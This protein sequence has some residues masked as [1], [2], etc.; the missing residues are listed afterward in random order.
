MVGKNLDRATF[1]VAETGQNLKALFQF[2]TTS[3]LF[4]LLRIAFSLI[5]RSLLPVTGTI[6]V[7]KGLFL[8]N[9]RRLVVLR[10]LRLVNRG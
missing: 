5:R 3:E 4:S 8:A 9:D 10:R 6:S 7:C 1:L 2:E